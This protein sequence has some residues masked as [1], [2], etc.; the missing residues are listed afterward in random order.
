MIR[1]LPLFVLYSLC[2]SVA[3]AQTGTG[4]GTSGKL[5]ADKDATRDL[6]K[7]N[8]MQDAVADAWQKIPLTQRRSI[9]VSESPTSYGTYEER[10]SNIFKI[11]EKIITYVEPV[12]Y[13][14]ATNLDGTY[15]YGVTVDFL[16]KRS[17]GKVLGGQENLLSVDK[18]SRVRNQELMLVLSLSLDAIDPGDYFVEYKIHDKQSS[19]E[20]KFTQNFVVR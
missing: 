16:V 11:G 8:A 5:G 7:I 18:K 14:W 10:K 2:C 4:W 1:L 13:T 20:S 17:D 19:K 6:A 15:S 3:L 12:G 9:F